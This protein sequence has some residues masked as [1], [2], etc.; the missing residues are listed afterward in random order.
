MGSQGR[1]TWVRMWFNYMLT[2]E[3]SQVLTFTSS[4][5]NSDNVCS[6]SCWL[7]A[8]VVAM[9][10]P[11]PLQDSALE[12]LPADSPQLSEIASSA[13][14]HRIRGHDPF[15]GQPTSNDRSVGKQKDLTP[16]TQLRTTLK[17]HPSFRVCG[18]QTLRW[19]SHH[20]CLWVLTFLY[21]PLSM[22]MGR[23]RNLLL[24]VERSKG[25]IMSLVQLPHIRLQHLFC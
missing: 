9:V 18:G 25:D 15:L 10:S 20:S 6:T 5:V 12:R 24:T 16:L 14:N 13:E 22:S 4:L 3:P 11:C 23:T 19:F 2:C 21:N 7:C 17:G 8:V 1:Q